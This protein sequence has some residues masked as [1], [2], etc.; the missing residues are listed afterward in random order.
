MAESGVTVVHCS[1]CRRSGD[2]A[3]LEGRF[4]CG[5]CQDWSEVAAERA[6]GTAVVSD[7]AGARLVPIPPLVPLRQPLRI[8]PGWQVIYNEFYEVAPSA[9]WSYQQDVLMARND[10]RERLVDLSWTLDEESSEWGFRLAVWSGD[11]DELLHSFRS[12]DREA[13]VAELERLFIEILWGRL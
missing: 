2:L 1:T 12:R 8:P 13:V 4:W 9:E 3:L 10:S 7:G 6:D 11:W 5:W